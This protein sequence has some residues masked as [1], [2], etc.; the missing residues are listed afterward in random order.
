M[1]KN[2]KLKIVISLTRRKYKIKHELL[3]KEIINRVVDKLYAD[4]ERIEISNQQS[5]IQWT[6]VKQVDTIR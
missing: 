1:L 4:G 5:E 3:K 6:I 2:R